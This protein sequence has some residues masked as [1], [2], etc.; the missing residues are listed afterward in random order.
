MVKKTIAFLP[1]NVAKPLT[2]GLAQEV[3]IFQLSKIVFEEGWFHASVNQRPQTLSRIAAAIMR[4]RQECVI[5][6]SALTTGAI[7]AVV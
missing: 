5:Q 4:K 1:Q 6:V 7:A 3:P 2:L